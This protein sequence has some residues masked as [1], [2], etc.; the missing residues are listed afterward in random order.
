ME[1]KTSHVTFSCWITSWEISKCLRAWTLFYWIAVWIV[2]RS[3]QAFLLVDNSE[4]EDW[5]GKRIGRAWGIWTVSKT[6]Y[7]I[8]KKY[9]ILSRDSEGELKY[10]Q[11]TVRTLRWSKKRDLGATKSWERRLV[12]TREGDVVPAAVKVITDDKNWKIAF[13]G[14][15]I[16][17]NWK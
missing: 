8:K 4:T 11:C 7:R 15:S 6:K 17:W 1:N 12:S 5:D 3:Y 9:W 14:H 16:I 13:Q 10:V 2:W